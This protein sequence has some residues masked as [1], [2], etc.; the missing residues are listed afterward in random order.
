MAI[1]NLTATT[2]TY[3]RTAY[4]ALSSTNATAIVSNPAASSKCFRVTTLIASNV[5]GVNPCDITVSYYTQD[6]I[7][8][9]AYRV[10]STTTIAPD[11]SLI[12]IDRDTIIYLEEDRSIGATASAADDIE[13]LCSYEEIS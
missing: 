12:V 4:V 8:G 9:T 1:K 11:S 5:D 10:V 7:G 2:T 3:G 13:I 6:D